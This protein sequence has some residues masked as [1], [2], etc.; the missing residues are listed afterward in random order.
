MVLCLALDAERVVAAVYHGIPWLGR[1][2]TGRA[3]VKEEAVEAQVRG[4]ALGPEVKEEVG[5]GGGVGF[6]NNAKTLVIG[7]DSI[8]LPNG[9]GFGD[10]DGLA[11]E[12]F[13]A[14]NDGVFTDWRGMSKRSGAHLWRGREDREACLCGAVGGGREAGA[15][16]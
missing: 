10:K 9:G 13:G 1:H 7:V 11:K 12:G 4:E 8:C 3:W 2:D 14:D 15:G 6:G 5:D 16:G